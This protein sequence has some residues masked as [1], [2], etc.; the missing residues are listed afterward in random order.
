MWRVGLDFPTIEIRYENLNIEAL[1]HVGSRGLPTFINATINSLES[2]VKALHILPNKKMPLN[3]LHDVSGAIKPKRSRGK[4]ELFLMKRGGEEIYV[5]PLGHQSKDL[6]S[7]FE[8]TIELPYVLVQSVL[9]GV[10][11]YSMMN[12]QWTAA[13]FFWYLFYMYFTL[14]YFTFYGML[15]VGLTPSYNIAAIVSSAFYGIWNVF[16]GFIIARPSMPV[17]W[18]WYYWA[19]PVS[20]TLYGL[21]TSQFGDLDDLLQGSNETVR[22]FLKSYFEFHHDFLGVVAVVVV[23]FA[24]LFAF[25]FGVSIK[26]LNFQRR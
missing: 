6:I 19:C 24:V 11:V 4:R 10:I 3:I 2:M 25:L 18:S 23:G 20:W 26:V 13:K 16:S 21:V 1:A 5:G 7:Y 12:F 8:V 17:W 14:L 15:C 9:Y 22:G